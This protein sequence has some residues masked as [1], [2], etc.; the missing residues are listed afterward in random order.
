M[1]K[2]KNIKEIY[3]SLPE[4]VRLELTSCIVIEG[5]VTYPTAWRYG[6]GQMTPPYLYRKF[7]AEKR[8]ALTGK[9][10]SADQMWQI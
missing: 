8:S 3:E 9:P 2:T 10:F 6:T 5:R 4:S 1:A 7:I